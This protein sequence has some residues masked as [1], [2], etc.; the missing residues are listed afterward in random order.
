MLDAQRRD[1]TGQD[2]CPQGTGCYAEEGWTR[3][4]LNVGPQSVTT[5]RETKT[6]LADSKDEL[7]GRQRHVSSTGTFQGRSL[8]RQ[9]VL[10]QEEEEW[11]QAAASAP[12]GSGF[13]ALKVPANQKGFPR[14]SHLT[15]FSRLEQ[16]PHTLLGPHGSGTPRSRVSMVLK[17]RDP[18]GLDSSNCCPLK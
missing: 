8:L 14:G 4:A 3:V 7:C 17:P 13:Q 15:S 11:P 1:L 5:R 16:V 10:E 6:G 12:A 18:Q 2:T 9:E